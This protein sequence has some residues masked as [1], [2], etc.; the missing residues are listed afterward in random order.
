MA[1]ETRLFPARTR[2]LGSD[3]S[4]GGARAPEVITITI[5]RLASVVGCHVGARQRHWLTCQPPA[6]MS[7]SPSFTPMS[8]LYLCPRLLILGA[9]LLAGCSRTPVPES[10]APK[11]IKIGFL[12]KQPEEPWF[13]YQW[14]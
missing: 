4:A 11:T 2:R 8:S 13:Q 7:P 12:V 5:R 3:E 10:A 9:L 6:A 1:G 14:K